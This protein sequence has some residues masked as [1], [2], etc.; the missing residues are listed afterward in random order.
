M[1]VEI[2]INS[3]YVFNQFFV[4]DYIIRIIYI[5]Y[6]YDL[7]ISQMW[8]LGDRLS[9]LGSHTSDG[10]G[11]VICCL[12]LGRTQT[13][14]VSGSERSKGLDQSFS[15][16]RWCGHSKQIDV[17]EVAPTWMNQLYFVAPAAPV[18]YLSVSVLQNVK[19]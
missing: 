2:L 4:V 17:L 12:C 16:N 15:S 13:E 11:I 7:F 8:F 9:Q 18:V 14:A 6:S 3:I 10:I 1:V 19:K 5:A